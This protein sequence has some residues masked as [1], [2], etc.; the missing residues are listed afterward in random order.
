[1][2]LEEIGFYTLSDFR[3]HHSSPDRRL[4]RCELILTKQCN[5]KCPY[6]RRVGPEDTSLQEACRVVSYW[7]DQGC[8]NMR[9][10]GGEPTIWHNLPF[11]AGFARLHAGVEHVAIS[12]NGTAELDTYKALLDAGV[13]DFSIS[14]D[15]CC[16]SKAGTMMGVPGTLVKRVMRTIQ[17]LSARTYVSIGTVVTEDNADDVMSVLEFALETKVADVR[18]IPAAQYM[19]KLE[20]HNRKGCYQTI[21]DAVARFPIFAYRYNRTLLGEPV[22]GMTWTDAPHCYLGLDDMVVSGGKHYP[23]VIHLREGGAPIGEIGPKTRIERANWVYSHNPYEDPICRKNCLDV[24]VAHNNV[25]KNHCPLKCTV[26]AF[27]GSRGKAAVL[28]DW[29]YSTIPSTSTPCAT[30]SG[31]TRSGGVQGKNCCADPSRKPSASCS[32]KTTSSG[33]PT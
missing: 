22:R 23:C 19:P 7:C 8:R 9:F 26:P 15:T 6:C 10:S 5:L 30:L 31:S 14:L 18:V 27:A 2:K 21:A 3:A 20:L 1:M 16:A 17:Y 28:P 24:C 25:S 32:C 29:G 13:N 11:L 12:T 4:E 33:G